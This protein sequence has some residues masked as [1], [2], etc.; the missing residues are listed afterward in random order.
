[1]NMNMNIYT[2]LIELNSSRHLMSFMLYDRL[3]Q[4][5]GSYLLKLLSPPVTSL[6][7][8]TLRRQLSLDRRDLC[9]WKAIRS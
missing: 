9:S 7:L 1:M 4:R 6:V 2:A 3:F 5:V 8:G